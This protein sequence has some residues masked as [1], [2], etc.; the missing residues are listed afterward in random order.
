MNG[1]PALPFLLGIQSQSDVTVTDNIKALIPNI[2]AVP[3]ELKNAHLKHNSLIS[4]PEFLQLPLSNEHSD[5]FTVF[6]DAYRNETRAKGR[7]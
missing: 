5:K 6:V 2:L 1:L 3:P 7:S 4:Q